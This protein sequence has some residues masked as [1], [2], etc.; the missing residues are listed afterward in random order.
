[1]P[2]LTPNHP[3]VEAGAQ[4]LSDVKSGAD[5]ALWAAMDAYLEADPEDAKVS[6]ERMSAA[7]AA[8]L[9]HYTADDLRDTPGGRAL[10]S[11]GWKAALTQLGALAGMYAK[12]NDTLTAENLR[13]A[14]RRIAEHNP[15]REG[16]A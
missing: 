8:A 11:A 13:Y 2:D 15:Y 9:E 7:L 4:Q 10:L 12:Y 14:K 5:D 16:D 1:M 3:A 6:R